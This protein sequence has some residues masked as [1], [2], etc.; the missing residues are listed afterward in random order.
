[1]CFKAQLYHNKAIKSNVFSKAVDNDRSFGRSG[2][3]VTTLQTPIDDT[4]RDGGI[5]REG[6]SRDGNSE[7]Y[8][9]GRVFYAATLH[10]SPYLKHKLLLGCLKAQPWEAVVVSSSGKS[11][12]VIYYKQK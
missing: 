12:T 7:A 8:S 5:E 2:T 11:K 1:M 10:R 6:G 3:A 9:H 4:G